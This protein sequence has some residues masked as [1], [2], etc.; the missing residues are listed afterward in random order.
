MRFDSMPSF[1]GSHIF[2]SSVDVLTISLSA[3]STQL[4]VMFRP[5]RRTIHHIGTEQLGEPLRLQ[6]IKSLRFFSIEKPA[7]KKN[8][9]ENTTKDHFEF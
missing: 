9:G 3:I 5:K 8:H 4:S 6:T 1:P 2:Q 7:G